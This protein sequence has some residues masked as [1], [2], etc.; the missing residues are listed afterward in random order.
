MALPLEQQIIDHLQKS[1]H[2]LIT[3]SSVPNEDDLASCLA[4]KL[5]LDER[6]IH[7]DIASYAAL[8]DRLT[9]LPNGHAFTPYAELLQQ[10]YALTIAVGAIPLREITFSRSAGNLT[11]HI[12][13]EYGQLSID[14]PRVEQKIPEYDLIIFIG[15]PDIEST[16]PL[17]REYA[18][19]VLATPSIVIDTHASNEQFGSINLINIAASSV[20]EMLYTLFVHWNNST[21]NSALSPDVATCLLTGITAHTHN[22]TNQKSTPHTLD[23]VSDLVRYGV[24]RDAIVK[25][26]YEN[27]KIEALRLL[28]LVLSHLERDERT[29][30][31]WSSINQD[32]FRLLQ[33]DTG[34]IAD[35]K[36]EIIPLA[37][38]V[39]VM[40]LLYHAPG[41][42]WW[43]ALIYTSPKALLNSRDF[44][45]LAHIT[46]KEVETPATHDG[47]TSLVL[48]GTNGLPQ[49]PRTFIEMVKEKS[50]AQR[51]IS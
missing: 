30:I 8:P 33:A 48:D 51:L 24:V 43:E 3:A 41:Q 18:E 5:F 23:V 21:G 42:E 14:P 17:A 16:G 45:W 25:H 9:F 34:T 44:P 20:A 49:H 38:H 26:L 2:I 31:V 37:S 40:I 46:H 32:D 7:S 11:F 22:F 1:T 19:F 27:K 15:T 35:L 39:G 28:G 6:G 10:E 13:P 12:K 4:L 47:F 36:H 29:G 50:N